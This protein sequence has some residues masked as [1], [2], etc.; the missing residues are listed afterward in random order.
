MYLLRFLQARAL[1][2]NI[3]GFEQSMWRDTLRLAEKYRGE[4]VVGI[5]IA[6]DEKGCMAKD[7]KDGETRR[8]FKIFLSYNFLMPI[9]D[10]KIS[11][12]L[13]SWFPKG[14]QHLVMLEQGFMQ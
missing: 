9:H 6:G 8:R 3:R 14:F 4:G 10:W 12:A 7:P 5:D 2:C 13:E 1:L 11:S